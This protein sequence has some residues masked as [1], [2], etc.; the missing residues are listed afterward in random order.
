MA[1][2]RIPQMRPGASR[3]IQSDDAGTGRGRE[4]PRRP[5]SAA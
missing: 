3:R 2:P 5:C 1:V 4:G